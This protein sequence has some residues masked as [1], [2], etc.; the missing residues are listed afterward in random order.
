M[1]F[2]CFTST[3]VQILTQK[4]EEQAGIPYDIVLEMDEVHPKFTCVTSFTGTK[5]QILALTKAPAW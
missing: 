3:K 5:E 1:C 2:T 4:L